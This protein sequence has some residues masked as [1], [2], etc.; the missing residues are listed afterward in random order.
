MVKVITE[1]DNAERD[2]YW[3]QL[4]R[5]LSYYASVEWQI[6]HLVRRYYRIEYETAN[7]ILG[8]LRYDSAVEHLNR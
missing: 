6:N 5:F 2:A 7:I 8:P 3:M 1:I 4:G